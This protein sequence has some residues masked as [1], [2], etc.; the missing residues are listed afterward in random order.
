MLRR[1]GPEHPAVLVESDQSQRDRQ[2]SVPARGHV[3]GGQFHQPVHLRLEGREDRHLRES[4]GQRPRAVQQP[5][6]P[7][8]RVPLLVCQHGVQLAALQPAQR[9]RRDDQL[10]SR[11]RQPPGVRPRPLQYDEPRARGV[12]PG[13]QRGPD[14][15]FAALR[16][17]PGARPQ[18][19]AGQHRPGPQR[20][21][22][23]HQRGAGG[24]GT[25]GRAQRVGVDHPVRGRGEEPAPDRLPGGG[26]AQQHRQPEAQE[27]RGD[28]ALPHPQGHDGFALGPSGPGQQTG[29]EHR[30]QGA[31]QQ[32]CGGDHHGRQPM[33]AGLPA[34][35]ASG[36]W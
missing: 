10:R 3:V 35:T 5:V 22:R 2:T 27:D 23:Q 8:R 20:T 16:P 7:G 34:G 21:A 11:P 25:T 26:R 24:P 29:G 1:G 17:P 32:E 9:R 28:H 13:Q 14:Q 4:P 18:H 33:S 19:L 30:G 15:Q 31:E 6:V 12:L 36:H